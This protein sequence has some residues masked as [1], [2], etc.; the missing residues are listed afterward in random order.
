MPRH[1]TLV[2]LSATVSHALH[3]GPHIGDISKPA[4]RRGG[5][6]PRASCVDPTTLA[7]DPSLVLNTN[8]ALT[9]KPAF[10]KAASAAIAA[11]LSK[12]ESYVAVCVTDSLDLLFGGSDD[13]CAV[14]CVYSIGSINQENNAALTAAISELLEK[15]GGVANSR[16]YLN[17]F[18]VPRA[19]C[20]RA[21]SQ[22]A[23]PAP[24]DTRVTPRDYSSHIL[25]GFRKAWRDTARLRL[26]QV[27]GP[28]ARSQA[29]AD[30]H[31]RTLMLVGRDALYTLSRRARRE[32][33][34]RCRFVKL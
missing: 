17:F 23:S 1:I 30:A 19:N 26:L 16:I 32:L 13:P 18:D 8:V 12:P 21:H 29:R 25:A 4:A 10:M 7:G 28:D 34:C 5:S 9:D 2:L 22:T 14:G 15:H 6:A 20:A 3:L 31:R 24:A 33:R 27:A 11:T